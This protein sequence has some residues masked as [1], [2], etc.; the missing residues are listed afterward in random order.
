[1]KQD[2]VV[3]IL[4]V[5]DQ[6]DEAE[7]IISLLR[8]AG[9]AV[10]PSNAADPKELELAL[11][12]KTSPDL[13]LVDMAI[14]QLDLETVRKQ[15]AATGKDIAMIALVKKADND[16]L[17]QTAE[18]GVSGVGL[19]SRPK[20]LEAVV[21]RVFQAL[22]MRRSVRQL[23]AS[24]RE[25]ERRCDA[26][27]DSS[28][29][30]IAYVHEGMHVR[31]NK[32]YLHLFG[33]E[34]FEEVE[35]MTLLDMIAPDD[36][37]DFKQLLRQV[38][39]GETPP[40]KLEIKAHRADGSE[41]EALIH[42]ANAS[43]EGE[44]CLQIIFRQHE[45]D[46]DEL[47]WRDNVTGLFN[48]SHMM[49]AVDK[50]VGEA[51]AGRSDQ[52][53]LII[54]PDGYRATLDSV[55]LS[56]A[57]SLLH[58]LAS[59]IAEQLGDRD[60]AGRISDHVF[61][62]LLV[63]R[64]H[65]TV[66][67]LAE[68]LRTSVEK[69]IFEAGTQS[70]NVTISI[71][72]SLLGERNASSKELLDQANERLRSVQDQGGNRVEIFNPAAREQEETEREQRWVHAIEQAL[73][74]NEFVL[75]NQQIIS[76]QGAEGEYYEI[77]LRLNGPNGEILP[78]SFMPA[79]ERNNLMPKIDKWVIE[80][81][82]KLLAQRINDGQSTTFLVKLSTQ[83]LQDATLARW[84]AGQLAAHKVPPKSLILEM[85][86][87][88]VMTSI[89]PA[90]AFVTAVRKLGCSF[91]LEQFGSGLKSFQLLQHIQ[92]DY[93]KIDRNFLDELPKNPENLS[94]INE[95]C[96]QAQEGGR[97]TIAEWVQD[98]ASTSL[99]FTA[100]VDFVQG[101]FLQEPEKIITAETVH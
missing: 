12:G 72:G 83:S 44:P 30:A 11:T 28:N 49:Q 19:V 93:L 32:A 15:V 99:L 35:G 41:F 53:L 21:R 54:E 57:D 46:V 3:R 64:E 81:A 2:N 47:R 18:L 58:G 71:G 6:L 78:K 60:V 62:V 98:A 29:D 101:N 96:K 85:P 39:S 20:Q 56:A 79:A 92:A 91:A 16:L 43:Y 84:L 22:N 73:A 48:R 26:L 55:G 76:L 75:F 8:N 77:L 88:K 95:I 89:K 34:S 42:F 31:A 74:N 5:Q 14:K 1:M 87:S 82:I 65:A 23:E 40:E 37:A 68:T 80:H 51:A 7:Q 52:A 94:K 63:E 69:G 13:V 17:V 4:F 36:A 61:A 24:L 86:E 97:K 9:I 25:T 10:R 45:V 33:M 38:T 59:V 100:G 90:A 70:I 50:A 66:S 27:L 67:E